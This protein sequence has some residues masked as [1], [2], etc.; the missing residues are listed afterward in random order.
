MRITSRA[1]TI[2]FFIT[3]GVCLVG[4]AVALNVGWIVLNWRRVVP[5]VLGIIFFGL[6][7]AGLVLNTIFLVREVRRNE[8]QDSFLNAVTHE[9]KT[10]ITSIRLYLETLERRHVEDT[11][12]HE[13]YRL[14]LED[15]DR[16][17]GTVEQVLRAGE[18][19]HRDARKDWRDVNF[20][21]LA[22]E[23]V[24]LV[25][26]R[27]HLSPQEIFFGAEPP[28]QITL[29]GNAEDLRTAIANLLENAVKYSGPK[30]KIEVT[31]ATPDLDKVL[32]SVRDSGIGLPR[33]ET[34]QIFKRFYRVPNRA[35]NQIK[36]TGLGLFIVRSIARRHGGDVTAESEGEGRGST[37]TMRLPRIYHV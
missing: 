24:E 22:R 9:L 26:L 17:L 3:L 25:R 13:F 2:A 36:G 11:Q 35:T 28:G 14:M 31:I 5:L 33:G 32:F 29:L 30:R 21:A 27:H 15:T 19:R 4:L 10:P 8:Q 6:I 1:K 37:F 18:V 23:S 16:L 7:I 20:T 34:K 12:R